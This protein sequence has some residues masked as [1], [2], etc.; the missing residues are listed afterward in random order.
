MARS[1]EQ[2]AYQAGVKRVLRKAAPVEPRDWLLAERWYDHEREWIAGEAEAAGHSATVGCYVFS[3][4]SPRTQY[5]VNRTAMIDLL[6]GRPVSRVLPASIVIAQ[7]VITEGTHVVRGPKTR[8]FA[9]CLVGCLDPVVVDVWMMRAFGIT[10]RDAPKSGRE[11]DFIEK[12][13]Q[14]AARRLHVPPRTLQA[15]LWFHVRGDKPSDPDW[16]KPYDW[17]DIRSIKAE[18]A[19]ADT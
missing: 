12:C 17:L 3:A 14:G 2:A 7:R 8:R 1:T 9:E 5:A 19:S 18:A 4:L 15:A 13:F 16:R 10:E 6:N 11:Y